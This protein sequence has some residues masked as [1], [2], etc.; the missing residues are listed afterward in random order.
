M[1]NYESPLIVKAL[2]L[3]DKYNQ[4]IYLYNNHNN[5]Y[6]YTYNKN[7]RALEFG[8]AKQQENYNLFVTTLEQEGCLG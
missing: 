5:T 3:L 4:Y 7:K 1:T 2:S 6:T 8:K